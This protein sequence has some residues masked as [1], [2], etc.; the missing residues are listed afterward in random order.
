M[1]VIGM[2]RDHCG[3][4]SHVNMSAIPEEFHDLFEKETFAHVVTLLPNGTLHSTPV[5]IDHDPDVDRVLINTERER[6]K[7]RNGQAD[8]SIA[9]SMTDPD[10]PYRFPSVTG[11]V[12]ELTTER[13]RE[14]IDTLSMRYL[15]EA[16]PSPIQ[17]ERVILHI[18]PDRV[19]TGG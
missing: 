17:S 3:V 12:E 13:A 10:N 19:Y 9:V 2:N 18:R 6:R 4:I 7:T 8:P 11:E 14:H 5:W 15:G 16:Y 1:T